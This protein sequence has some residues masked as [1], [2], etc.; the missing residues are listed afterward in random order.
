MPFD[1]ILISGLAILLAACLLV[2]SYR[3]STPTGWFLFPFT[4]RLLV[5]SVLPDG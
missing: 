2:D 1:V 4:K 5:Q 3:Q